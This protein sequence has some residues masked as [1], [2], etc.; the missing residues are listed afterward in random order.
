MANRP[1]RV[2]V[3]EDNPGDVEL[4]R[5]ALDT[6]GTGW[7]MTPFNDGAEALAFFRQEHQGGSLPDVVVLDMN[8]PKYGGLEILEAVRANKAFDAV[9]V[10]VL[11]S[12]SSPRDRSRIEAYSRVTYMT[13]PPDLDLYL[14]MGAKIGALAKASISNLD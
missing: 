12:S 7:E 9:P 3:V 8:L 4:L 6:D 2:L 5:M 14:A 1:I 10:M 11:T 13:K